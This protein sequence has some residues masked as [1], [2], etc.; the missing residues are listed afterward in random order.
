MHFKRHETTQ[1][2]RERE[3]TN[4]HMAKLFRGRGLI[5]VCMNNIACTS[6]TSLHTTHA[7]ISLDRDRKR[8]RERTLMK[9]A[10][11]MCKREA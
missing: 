10:Y 2:M 9:V 5:L 7:F 8:E 11:L 1:L 4:T 3:S 6:L